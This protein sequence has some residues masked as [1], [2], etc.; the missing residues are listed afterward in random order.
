MDKDRIEVDNW[1]PARDLVEDMER[2]YRCSECNRR[3]LPR[4]SWGM[5]ERF[6]GF[7]LP[8]H[9]KKGW[10]IKRAKARKL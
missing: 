1:C 2:Y 10:K 7:R 9:K 5:L 3:L 4:E 6:E 8:K